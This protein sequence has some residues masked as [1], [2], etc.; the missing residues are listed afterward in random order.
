MVVK[1]ATPATWE[2]KA[3][4]LGFKVS[5]EAKSE[6]KASLGNLVRLICLKIIN[7]KLVLQNGSVIKALVAKPEFS[8]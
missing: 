7:K 3:G 1:P 8:P 4:G 2:A 5:L 6:F